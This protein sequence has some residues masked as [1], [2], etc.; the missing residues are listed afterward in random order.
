[1]TADVAIDPKS[2][3]KRALLE[4]KD[5]KQRLQAAHCDGAEPIAVVGMGCRFPGNADGPEKFWQ[6]LRESVDAT[7][8]VPSQRWDVD[9]F[10]DPDPTAPGKMYVKRGGFL[11]TVDEFA[12]GFFNVSP[13]EAMGMDPQQRLL[14]EVAWEAL[15]HAGIPAV[16]LRGSRTGVFVGITNTDYASLQAQHTSLEEVDLHAATS[17]AL[18]FAAGRLAFA[19]GWHGPALAV[20]TACSSSLVAVHLACHS[21]RSKE[22]DLAI[23]AGVNLILS[24]A[25]NVVLCKAR[26][27]AADGRCKTFDEAAD[28]YGRGEG[29]GVVV[30]KRYADAVRDG[31]RVWAVVRG[32]AVNQDGAGSGLTVPNGAAQARVV[33][34]ALRSAGLAPDA[35]GYIEAHGTGTALGDPIELRALASV[36]KQRKTARPVA[37]GSVKTN[38]GH[39]ESAAGI[40]SF[41]KVVL[42]LH[43][44]EIPAHLHLQERNRHLDWHDLP[45]W[46]PTAHTPWT[47]TD[48]RLAAGVSSFGISGTN[49]HVVLER[50]PEGSLA[51]AGE[52]ASGCAELFTLSAATE[53][54]LVSFARRY[55][56]FLHGSDLGLRDVCFSAN[57]GRSHLKHRLA[58]VVHSKEEL[59]VQL[60]HLEAG[61]GSAG[62]TRRGTVTSSVQPRVAFLFTGQGAQYVAMGKE[63]FET[64]PVFRDVIERCTRALRAELGADLAELMFRSDG[65]LERLD[66]T[67]YAQPAL[68]ALEC[69]LAELWKSLGVIPE[70][71][72]GHSVGEYAA[73]CAAGVFSL[74]QG[75]RLIAKRGQLMH[76][77]HQG[78]GM[79][80]VFA[81][82][83]EVEPLL[84]AWPTLGIAAV[85][86]PAET[87]VSGALGDLAGLVAVL[88]ERA[89]KH[90]KLR[91]S[92]AF[93]SPLMAGIEQ[94]FRSYAETVAY[95]APRLEVI[96]NLT[97][98]RAGSEIAT[99]DYWVRHATAPVQFHD[100][101]RCLAAERYDIYVEVGPDPVL[102]GLARRCLDDGSAAW[103]PSLRRG[104]DAR[105][106]FLGAVAELEVR[107]TPLAFAALNGAERPRKSVLPTYPFE[108]ARCWIDTAKSGI[109]NAAAA[110]RAGAYQPLVPRRISSDF[111]P[112]VV[113]ETWLDL[114]D[115]PLLDD[116]RVQN[117]ILV[118]GVVQLALVEA[119]VVDLAGPGRLLYRDISFA[120]PLILDETGAH[121]VLIEM[122]PR[123]ER[124]WAFQILDGRADG[125][126]RA[127]YT[128]GRVTRLAD[129]EAFEVP[130]PLDPR[131]VIAACTHESSGAEF[132][133]DLSTRE[134][135][136]IGPAFQ[137]IERIWE[138]AGCAIAK[139]CLPATTYSSP[140]GVDGETW[141][142]LLRKAQFGE[143]YGQVLK[144]ALPRRE[145]ELYIGLGARQIVDYGL[146]PARELYCYA[147]VEQCA[148]DVGV[149]SILLLDERGA[150]QA[151]SREL[152]LRL[153][154][155]QLRASGARAVQRRRARALSKLELASLDTDA[156][157]RRLTH[158]LTEEVAAVVGASAASLQ[159]DV[160]LR[161][162][163]LDSL[164]AVELKER[165]EADLSCVVP[166][167]DLI[168][169]PQLQALV[170]RLLELMELTSP[171]HAP[172][173][174]AAP[175]SE[176][177]AATGWLVRTQAPSDP[178]LTVF[179]FPYGGGGASTFGHWQ[180]RL[181]PHVEVCA[182]E[183]PGRE[184]RIL[185]APMD[186]LEALVTQVV[187]ALRPAIVR[188]F[189]LFGH[190]M[191]ALIAFEVAR[192]LARLRLGPRQLL[193]SGF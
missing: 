52:P 78:G 188:P 21:L 128:S 172:D 41:I 19:F 88:G 100:S 183:L 182:V 93:H 135:H 84:G 142:W 63:L 115:L 13:R 107:G 108:R 74:D 54:A 144:A 28:G 91:V 156:R 174:S 83:R 146:A 129:A 163:G 184:S 165:L 50:A 27:L 11:D 111:M 35:L 150:V 22:S 171:E 70:A 8:E 95:G 20:D 14:L 158:Y 23:A 30:L 1:M 24:P 87:V 40:A 189:A 185:Q 15:E 32:S 141:G 110:R 86:G 155:G 176:K 148:N 67:V 64:E 56:D 193:V 60:A 164:L 37:I 151:E 55:A 140:A 92:H 97:G 31:D 104:K 73:A 192:R 127:V 143:V 136:D 80:A 102:L 166:I 69:A 47:A 3:L 66:A 98:Q 126:E 173:A 7:R 16:P 82:V 33:Q 26:M 162:L 51:T 103:V 58:C 152:Q 96:S 101:V 29:A 187:A 53:T 81:P 43:H 154:R 4:I 79:L 147:R 62:K 106:E 105:Q 116:H 12:A 61:A 46:I 137:C 157:L 90:K 149:G 59:A 120:A 113:L 130:A 9:A 178:G 123:G 169:G 89:F 112:A 168:Q 190:S 72:M 153:V 181:A 134:R 38:I 175:T 161:E 94:E 114:E 2:L 36:L 122:V 34:D 186:N 133:A 42:A 75:A 49:C 131:S 177:P 57:V 6:L 5:L 17:G 180:A 25:G 44:A 138:G 48:G 18:N 76:S 167:V 118:S 71:V 39:L 159:A 191:G 65:D 68:F 10:Y 132:Y 117:Q 170:L 45:L 119:A 77:S 139:L 160:S 109:S 85:N 179:C 124:T 121:R 145:G 125:S 99:A